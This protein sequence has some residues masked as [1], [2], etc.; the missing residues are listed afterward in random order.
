MFMSIDADNMTSVCPPVFGCN[1]C[2]SVTQHNYKVESTAILKR[3]HVPPI[4]H[5]DQSPTT[6]AANPCGAVVYDN[7]TSSVSQL[8]N[9]GRSRSQGA[10]HTVL[11]TWYYL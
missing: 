2:C 7:S 5:F 10:V 4:P 8:F 11:F 9:G 3:C 6:D 1:G